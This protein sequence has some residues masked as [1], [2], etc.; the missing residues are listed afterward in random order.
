MTPMQVRKKLQIETEQAVRTAGE[1][2][3]HALHA[4]A[5]Y[6]DDTTIDHFVNAAL[7]AV[8]EAYRYQLIVA[9]I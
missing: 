1:R 6:E 4:L 7:S 5:F 9:Q 8:E 3:Q 2:L